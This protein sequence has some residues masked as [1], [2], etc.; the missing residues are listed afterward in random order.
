MK[1]DGDTFKQHF[2]VFKCAT[3][4]SHTKR[5]GDVTEGPIHF[6]LI[7]YD[8]FSGN[9]FYVLQMWGLNAMCELNV[10]WWRR[11]VLIC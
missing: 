3:E 10:V 7:V 9:A 5:W 8:Y 2:L 11:A 6:V 1:Q 4:I